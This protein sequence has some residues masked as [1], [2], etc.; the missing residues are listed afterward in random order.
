MKMNLLVIPS[1]NVA[2]LDPKCIEWFR[3]DV[4]CNPSQREGEAI[5]YDSPLVVCKLKISGN[6]FERPLLFLLVH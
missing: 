5:A 4:K 2:I 6:T 3:D 1:R